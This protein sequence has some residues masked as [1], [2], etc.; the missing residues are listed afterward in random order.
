[1][2]PSSEGGGPFAQPGGGALMWLGDV[3]ET[4]AQAEARERRPCCPAACE[5]LGTSVCRSLPWRALC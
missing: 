3:A 5:N 4:G 1:V 2:A